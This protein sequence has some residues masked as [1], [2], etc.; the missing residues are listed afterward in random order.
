[1]TLEL[2]HYGQSRQKDRLAKNALWCVGWGVGVGVGVG[3]WGLEH[4]L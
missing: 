3:G 4:K 2:N 1:M